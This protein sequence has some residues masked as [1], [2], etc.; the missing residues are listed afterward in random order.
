MKKLIIIMVLPL[1]LCSMNQEKGLMNGDIIF[2]ESL[3][4]QG[5][6]LKLATKSRY[7]HMGI[8]YKIKNK[9]YVYE[10][11][12]P[13]CFTP[14]NKW[15]ARGKDSH[16]VVK[17]IKKYR[18]K[19]TRRNIKRMKAA[20]KNFIGKNYDSLFQWSDRNIYCAELVWKIYKRALGIE[21]GRLQKF[22]DFDLSHPD[23]KKLIRKRYGSRFNP[24]ETI[25]SP[26]QM[27]E[28]DLL[29]TVRTDN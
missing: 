23:V 17:R 10:A 16:Y 22:R 4:S 13:V 18:K 9:W 28:S 24:D 8:V 14:L 26:V 1:M 15:I 12:Q 19:L 3:S 20:G 5:K 27:F 29:F 7:T 6:E 21:I 11:V 25:I 2:H